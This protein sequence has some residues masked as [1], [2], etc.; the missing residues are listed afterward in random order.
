M[1]AIRSEQGKIRVEERAAEP[2][3]A[4]GEAVVAPTRLAVDVADALAAGAGFSG[5]LGPE[6]VGV[7]ERVEGD[8]NAAGRLAG[9]RVVG[10]A[11]VPCG[12]CERCR[13]G[14]GL[15]C[16]AGATL[17]LDRRDGCF[18]GRFAIPAANLVTIPAS[19]DDDRAVFAH[20]VGRVL[21][22]ARMLRLERQTF[23]SV[24]GDGPLAL[25]A[26]QVMARRN[27]SVRLL[28]VHGAN[29]ELCAKWGVKHRAQHEVGR[30]HDQ[31]VVFDCAGDAG[32]MELA[33]GLVRPR[34]SIVLM[35]SRT[36][37]AAIEAA[38][39]VRDELQVFGSRGSAVAEAVS[40]LAAGRVDV[41]S[42]VSR[43]LRFDDGPRA[44]PAAA[45]PGALKILLDAT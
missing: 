34:G 31:D 17:G 11:H 13:S 38:A 12:R 4:P 45:E 10:S 21:H 44:I 7:V 25:L 32:A 23:V 33:L 28:G 36:R 26:A 9:K 3:A 22:A 5:V 35:R 29:L 16:A 30:R 1:R 42:L 2:Q 41:L 24:L 15:H 20:A 37:E 8:A 14:L 18:A 6:F 39:V 27:A 43:R 19:L 40:E